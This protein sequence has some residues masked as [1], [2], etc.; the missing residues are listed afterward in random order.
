M[1]LVFAGHCSHAPGITS[2]RE[3]AAPAARDPFFAQHAGL[4]HRD[5][6]TIR[7]TD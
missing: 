2:R 7:G 5:G 6:G 1:S 4:L 3:Q